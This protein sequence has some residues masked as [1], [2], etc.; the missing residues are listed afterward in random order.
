M[1][2]LLKLARRTGA[3]RHFSQETLM[4]SS[5]WLPLLAVTTLG[6]GSCDS[7]LTSDIDNLAGNR[8]KVDAIVDCFPNLWA[9]VGGVTDLAGTWKM[10][11]GTAPDPVGLATTINGD[12]SITAT[13]G[14]GTTSITMDINF[15]G[16]NGAR[17]DLTAVITA[18]V[19]LGDKIDAAATELRDLFGADEKFIHGVYSITGGGISATGEALTGIIGGAL[20]QNELEE[21]RSTEVTV[22]T[23]IPVVDSTTI[24]DSAGTPPCT[25]TFTIPDLVTDEEP[26]QEYPRGTIT[27]EI[28]DGTTVVNASIVFDKTAVAKITV[29]DLTGGFDFNLE[30]LTLSATF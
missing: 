11:G 9:F 18:P 23:G 1:P 27:L 3:S 5:R 6:L 14:V 25:L 17:Q 28:N 2:I 20:N 7:K 8:A 15:Y 24:T 12:G 19:T 29:D 16:P 10:N 26:G 22:T 4:R 30:T 13:L 21:L